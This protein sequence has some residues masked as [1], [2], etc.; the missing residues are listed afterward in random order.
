MKQGT[1]VN[2]NTKTAKNV[3]KK[4]T[5][6]TPSVTTAKTSVVI[7]E[8]VTGKK[9]SKLVSAKIEGNRAH[10]NE[11]G[12]L[13][14]NLSQLKKHAEKYVKETGLTISEIETLKPSQFVAFLT[15]KEK[16]RLSKN[17]N[18]FTFWL[19]LS[20]VGRYAKSK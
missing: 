12:T 20:L 13:S 8:N 5:K 3:T 6:V 11:L 19:L 7:A 18:L 10:K 14:F 16:G 2:A 1:K 15:D 9:L 17:G 4:T